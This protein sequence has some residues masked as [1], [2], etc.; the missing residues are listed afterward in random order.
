MKRISKIKEW[1]IARKKLKIEYENRGITT[2]ELRFKGC[3]RNNALGFHHRHKR[4]WYYSKPELL[5]DFD[6]TI[7]CCNNCHQKIENDRELN[8]ETFK[9]LRK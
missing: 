4:L 9:R 5:G 3:W 7:L 2:C 8:R 6:Q 1:E